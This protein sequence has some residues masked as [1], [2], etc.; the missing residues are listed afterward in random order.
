MI[1]Q[2]LVSTKGDDSWIIY[3]KERANLKTNT[4]T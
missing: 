1:Y 4:K 2:Y 3:K